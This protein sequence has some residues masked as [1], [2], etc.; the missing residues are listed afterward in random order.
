A[1]RGRHAGPSVDA[2]CEFVTLGWARNRAPKA[3]LGHVTFGACGAQADGARLRPSQLT[4]A[5][6]RREHFHGRSCPPQIFEPTG[7]SAALCELRH[8]VRAMRDRMWGLNASMVWPKDSTLTLRHVRRS[9]NRYAG[10]PTR[11]RT[12]LRDQYPI[13]RVAANL[14]GLSA[15]GDPARSTLSASSSS[16][17]WRQPTTP[18][19]S[20]FRGTCFVS[21]GGTEMTPECS[22][23]AGPTA[24]KSASASRIRPSAISA[25]WLE[26]FLTCSLR[27]TST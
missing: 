5:F 17:P 8:L 13:H 24:G 18:L 19:G 9:R 15:I 20:N 16:K 11:Q 27:S 10:Y 23:V 6:R 3:G 1:G 26:L 21:P 25:S 22:G 14:I 2:R 7:R 4:Q 12:A